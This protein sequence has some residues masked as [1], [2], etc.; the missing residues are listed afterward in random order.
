MSISEIAEEILNEKEISL[1]DLINYLKKNNVEVITKTIKA[2]KITGYMYFNK[3]LNGKKA[4]VI[5][6]E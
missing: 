1:I 3:K 6:Y 5:I 4:L 2:S